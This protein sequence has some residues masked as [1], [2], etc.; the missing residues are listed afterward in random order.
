[1]RV[2]VDAIS[3]AVLTGWDHCAQSI[4]TI[5]STRLGSLLMARDF[6][7]DVPGLIDQP[8]T[9]RVI[10]GIVG[11]VADALRRD[12][13]GFRLRSAR[14]LAMG[15]DG[16]AQLS[17]EGLFYPNGHL[18]DFSTPQPVQASIAARLALGSSVPQGPLMMPVLA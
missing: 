3:G 8:G 11:A 1:M 18:G 6:G 16:V 5:L 10:A 9:P 4:A 2:G 17:V 12:E 13:P 7:S 14:V 15:P